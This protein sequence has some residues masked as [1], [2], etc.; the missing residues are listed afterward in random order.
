[1]LI[2]SVRIE[3]FVLELSDLLFVDFF[4]FFMSLAL[5]L[6]LL[7]LDLQTFL[8]SLVGLSQIR[9]E[10][11]RREAAQSVYYVFE[12]FL[13]LIRSFTACDLLVVGGDRYL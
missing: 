5:V 1:M 8:V 6:Q 10:L 4:D 3:I 11:L 2:R 13:F 7:Y 12:I 9:L